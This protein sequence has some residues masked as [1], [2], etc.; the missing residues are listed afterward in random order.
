MARAWSVLLLVAMLAGGCIGGNGDDA[1]APGN[2]ADG[3]GDAGAPTGADAGGKRAS[4]AGAVDPSWNA[5]GCTALLFEVRLPA[6]LVRPHLPARFELYEFPPGVS[7]A[8]AFV[9]R[10]DAAR[11]ADGFT[12]ADGLHQ[13][14]L[15]I[16]YLPTSGRAEFV[17]DWI[18]S[19]QA[20]LA[21]LTAHGVTATAGDTTF[22]SGATQRARIDSK[23]IVS[24]IGEVGTD[25]S[26]TTTRFV[27]D[28][29]GVDV[30]VDALTPGSYSSDSFTEACTLESQDAAW[31]ALVQAT[32]RECLPFQTPAGDVSF[33]LQG[34]G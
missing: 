32:V 28:A 5:T 1:T 18:V 23:A 7:Y 4:A 31:Q 20:A 3:V 25:T 12:T 22:E 26:A 24:W 15:T 33:R 10:C 29:D 27:Q 9:F 14:L 30:E 16:T 11:L 21:Q 13:A 6:Q 17:L 34:P 19:D 2:G 8:H